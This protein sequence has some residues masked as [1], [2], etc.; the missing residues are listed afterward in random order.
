MALP[1]CRK[2]IRDA[3]REMRVQLREFEKNKLLSVNQRKELTDFIIKAEHD[4]SLKQKYTSLEELFG[5]TFGGEDDVT[6][7]N[8][9][10]TMAGIQENIAEMVQTPI[11]RCHLKEEDDAMLQRYLYRDPQ[12]TTHTTKDGI[13]KRTVFV[14]STIDK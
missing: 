9:S 2:E 11:C 10:G 6:E 13:Q 3:H 7:F 12:N 4:N 5:K 8:F 1:Y 14:P